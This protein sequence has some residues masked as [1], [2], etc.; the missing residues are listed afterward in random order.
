MRHRWPGNVRELQNVIER[1]CILGEDGKPITLDL[2]GLSLDS[3]PSIRPEPEIS[4]SSESPAPTATP[5]PAPATPA[6][7]PI[8]ASVQ[9]LHVVEKTAIFQALESTG[10]NR[11][12]AAETLQ[13]S[14]RT[15]RNKLAEYRVQGILPEVLTEDPAD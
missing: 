9:P 3:M 6:P 4:L 5:I 2:M 10:G 1:A 14:I 15:L 8:L 12:K 11:T 7:A 13:I